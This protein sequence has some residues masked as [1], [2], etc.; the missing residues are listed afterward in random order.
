MAIKAVVFDAYGT[1]FDVQSV[2][3]VTEIAFP[4]HGEVITQIWRLKQLEYSW[5]R[6]LMGAYEDFSTVTRE[7]LAYTL[8]T[9]GL[10]AT[11]QRIA[12]IASAY[13]ALALYPE[14]RR[15]LEQ[16]GHLRLA[17]FSNGSAAML[18]RLVAQ[19]G[20]ESLIE[21]VISVDEIGVYKPDPRGY[22]HVETRLGLGRDDILFVSSN[23]FDIAGAKAHGF[24]VARIARLPPD[25]L[26][27]ELQDG[28]PLG[29]AQLF[30]ALRMRPEQLGF[31]ADVTIAALTDLVSYAGRENGPSRG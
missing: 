2:G 18:E 10:L 16:L 30:K 6:A 29:P 11:P 15:A 3:A 8:E 31:D 20:I 14:A 7:S 13:D 27:R 23:G 5:L 25:V 4:G 1:L 28:S 24:E 26:H 12:E 21:T 22:R 17:I 19:A 9:L